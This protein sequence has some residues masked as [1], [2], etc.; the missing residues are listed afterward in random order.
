[1]FDQER[2]NDKSAEDF[3]TLSGT[4]VKFQ[5]FDVPI[6]GLPLLERILSKHPNFMSKCT[7]GNAMR[8]EM[9]KSLVAVLL[10]IECTPIKRLNLHKVLEWKDVLSELQSMRFYVGFILDW[11]KTTATSCIIRDG[12]MKLAELTMKIADLEKEIAAKDARI[13]HLVQLDPGGFVLLYE[14]Y[15]DLLLTSYCATLEA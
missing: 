5:Q 3:Y 12:E 13:G 6:E 14:H 8:K 11:L 4:T 15:L 2:E 7:Y 10:D 1:M 9:F